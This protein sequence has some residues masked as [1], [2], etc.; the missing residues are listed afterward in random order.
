MDA[1]AICWRGRILQF[2]VLLT[3]YA[4]AYGLAIVTA[5]PT[6]FGTAALFAQK[7]AAYYNGIEYRPLSSQNNEIRLLNI[8]RASTP[9]DH[10]VCH[11][12][13]TSLNHSF[14]STFGYVALSYNWG[15]GICGRRIILAGTDVEITSN[16]YRALL[17]LRARGYRRVWADGLCINQAD[18]EERSQQRMVTE[19]LVKRIRDK[20]KD[21][22]KRKNHS[23]EPHHGNVNVNE[24]FHSITFPDV[25]ITEPYR[26][27]LVELLNH[28]YWTRIWIIQEIS[29]NLHL[30]IIWGGNVLNLDELAVTLDMYTHVDGIGNSPARH[31][32]VQLYSIRQ[33][34]LGLRPLSLLNARK[35]C[36]QAKAS[37]DQDR[38]FALLGLTHD[39]PMLVPLPS[40]QMPL[41]ML[42]RDM[43]IK[44]I[45]AIGNLDFIVNK[46]HEVKSWYPDWFDSRTWAPSSPAKGPEGLSCF[47]RP[48]PFGPYYGAS[49]NFKADLG[50]TIAHLGISFKGLCIGRVTA[51]SPTLEEAKASMLERSSI[52][53]PRTW[54]DYPRVYD[55]DVAEALCWLLVYPTDKHCWEDSPFPSDKPRDF[56]LLGKLLHRNYSPDL[57]QWMS[58]CEK[59]G[60]DIDGQPLISYF[61]ERDTIEQVMPSAYPRLYRTIQRNLEADMRLGSINGGRRLGWFHKNTKVGDKVV[62]FL[63]SAM[64]CVIRSYSQGD[65]ANYSH[66]TYSIVGPCVLHG[67]MHGE[68]FEHG[69]IERL[70]YFHLI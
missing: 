3:L 42:C 10:I 17:E 25:L 37:I 32:I 7:Y 14:E 66:R 28:E 47:I 58:Y 52:R 45:Q 34:K 18:L 8:Q 35:M 36:H 46:V 57:I 40:Y 26:R 64:P 11:L 4:I 51:C 1:T 22:K 31:H 33:L 61:S 38:I 41:N 48:E 43:T 53:V 62:I 2:G 54:I 16:L 59:Q 69:A 39:G 67:V 6:P 5:P 55:T 20:E 63:G 9:D 12:E 13:H 19:E 44:M 49:R 23:K 21:N 15:D 70:Q 27:A 56:K 24:R 60:F 65:D 68:A 29:I 30:E 50:P